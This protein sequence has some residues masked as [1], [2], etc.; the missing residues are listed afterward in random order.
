MKVKLRNSQFLIFNSRALPYSILH[1]SYEAESREPNHGKFPISKELERI[2]PACTYPALS[3]HTQDSYVNRSKIS[4]Q[5]GR[6]TNEHQSKVAR[7]ERR[8]LI[9]WRTLHHIIPNSLNTKQRFS[10]SSRGFLRVQKYA[11]YFAL[12]N[13]R[14]FIF[15]GARKKLLL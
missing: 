4:I 5:R 14:A 11:D 15:I 8:L 9:G 3:R 1:A 6:A 2:G 10:V 12:A 7:I 13:F